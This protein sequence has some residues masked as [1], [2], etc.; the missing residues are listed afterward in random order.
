LRRTHGEEISPGEA[1]MLVM[2][3]LRHIRDPR[4]KKM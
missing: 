2:P 3:W 4:Q 1:L